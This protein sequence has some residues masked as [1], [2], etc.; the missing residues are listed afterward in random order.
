M[1]KLGLLNRR[2]YFPNYIQ[3]EPI[4]IGFWK[5]CLR[6]PFLFDLLS[7]VNIRATS[8]YH[9]AYVTSENKVRST[10]V[11]RSFFGM[12]Q[13]HTTCLNERSDVD[14]QAKD[15]HHPQQPQATALPLVL[16]SLQLD[17]SIYS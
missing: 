10:R 6:V 14:G 16:V 4:F 13:R 5:D 2:S 3:F 7:G 12:A 17:H 11:V 9:H 1:V 8:A 15:P